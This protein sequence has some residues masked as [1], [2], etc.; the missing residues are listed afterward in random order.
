MFRLKFARY[1]ETESSNTYMLNV[2]HAGRAFVQAL[3]P[4]A[5][6]YLGETKI[7]RRGVDR[8]READIRTLY[9]LASD[10]DSISPKVAAELRAIAA[11]H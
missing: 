6:R 8:A 4:S 2:R 9:E 10:Y 11:R 3:I 7:K 5:A 1:F